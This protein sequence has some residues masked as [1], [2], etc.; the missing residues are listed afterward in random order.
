M[1]DTPYSLATYIRRKP[2]NIAGQQRNQPSNR[3]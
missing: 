2:S 1:R 3:P